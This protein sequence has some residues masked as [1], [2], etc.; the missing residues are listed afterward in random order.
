MPT[1]I[2]RA[3]TGHSAELEAK[4][5]IEAAWKFAQGV[6]GDYPREILP[7]WVENKTA[8]GIQERVVV[9]IPDN[10]P[11]DAGTRTEQEERFYAWV[12][13]T[14]KSPMTLF[15]DIVPPAV[16]EEAATRILSEADFTEIEPGIAII[17]I[18]GEFTRSGQTECFEWKLAGWR[19]MGSGPT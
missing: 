8:P 19:E 15:D 7:V 16:A 10:R 14:I 18:D 17:E 5:I 3:W 4:S 12:A 11:F 13:E 1:Y 9:Q 2:C 6:F